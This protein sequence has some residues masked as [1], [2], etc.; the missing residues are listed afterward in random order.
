[1]TRR[2][3]TSALSTTLVNSQRNLISVLRAA[4]GVTCRITNLKLECQG[5]KLAYEG[6]RNG[7]AMIDWK[8]G[9]CKGDYLRALRDFLGLAG[10]SRA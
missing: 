1:M 3:N 4:E 7:P 5:V 9:A 8:N 6:C 10:V 2:P